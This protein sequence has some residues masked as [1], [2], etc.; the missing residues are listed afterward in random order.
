MW[1]NLKFL[2]MWSNFKFIHMTEVVKSEICLHLASVWRDQKSDRDRFRDIFS[3]PNFLRDGSGTFFGTKF[4]PRPVPRLFPV[5]N[6]S[7]T[8]SGTFSG[9]KFFRDR[10][11]YH[12]KNTKVPGTGRDRYRDPNWHQNSDKKL[13][14][15]Y[16]KRIQKVWKGQVGKSRD[17]EVSR[18][19]PNIS[20]TGSET[21]FGT[22]FFPRPIPGLFSVPNF[23]GT[24]SKTFFCTKFFRDRFQDFF[25]YQFFSRPVPRLFSVPNFSDT[26][27]DTIKKREQF[28]GTGIPG[29]GTSHSAW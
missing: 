11:R 22:N 14:G 2:H 27:S 4:S 16:E 26:G 25:R 23:F 20:V 18:P 19:R 15:K 28:P 3:V 8:D 13:W 10:F 21:F 12:P 5:L 29:T 9:T 1:R 17:R 7:E 6:F 24:G